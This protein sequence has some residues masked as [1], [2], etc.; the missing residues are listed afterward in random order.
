MKKTS[1]FFGTPDFALSSLRAAMQH[2][3]VLAVVTQPDRPRGRGQQSSPCEVKALALENGLTVFSPP[4]LRKDS[5]EL[6]RFKAWMLANSRPDLVLVTAY[7]NILPQSYLDWP[8]IGPIN[9]HASLLPRWRGAAPIQRCLEAG[10]LETGVAL[11]KMVY[12]LDAGDVLAE[13]RIHLRED[14]QSPELWE[15][16]SRLGGKLLGSFLERFEGSSLSGK[17][18]NAAQV[19]LAP[20]LTKE[21]AFWKPSWTALES[22]N[23]VRAFAG[24]PG[25][26]ASFQGQT[27]KI[28]RTSL[29]SAKNESLGAPKNGIL[30]LQGSDVHLGCNEIRTSELSILKLEEI[31][32]P[33]KGPTKAADALRNYFR[34][35]TT[36][37][38]LEFQTPKG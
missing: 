22:H 9:V 11:Q 25:V 5:E 4:G 26:K 17:P 33:G 10:D 14:I 34:D 18:Q 1:V 12:E 38:S 37:Q 13:D 30:R 29:I 16:L 28:C 31:Q 8:T 21:E 7:G 15:T 19:T 6:A 23:R 27:V 32:F 24:W 35:L 2:T 3:Q 36:G 20:K